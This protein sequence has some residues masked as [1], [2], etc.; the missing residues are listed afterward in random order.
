MDGTRRGSAC[1]WHHRRTDCRRLPN[2]RERGDGDNQPQ[3]GGD[4]DRVQQSSGGIFVGLTGHLMVLHL[5][6]S[7]LAASRMVVEARQAVVTQRLI[8]G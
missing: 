3:S 6:A 5:I 1:R 4:G 8:L 2:D 7:I